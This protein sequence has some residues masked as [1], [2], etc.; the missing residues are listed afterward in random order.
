MA[1]GG[2]GVG[3]RGGAGA[4]VEPPALIGRGHHG[5]PANDGGRRGRWGRRGRPRQC[6]QRRLRPAAQRAIADARPFRPGLVHVHQRAGGHAAHRFRAG[7]GACVHVR[8]GYAH[9]LSQRPVR[10]TAVV[11]AAAGGIG[12]R[13]RAQLRAGVVEGKYIPEGHALPRH[14]LRPALAHAH[15]VPPAAEGDGESVR[16]LFDIDR[17]VAG[18]IDAQAVPAFQR[19]VGVHVHGI[20]PPV[21]RLDGKAQF[22]VQAA[23]AGVLGRMRLDA[24]YGDDLRPARALPQRLRKTR[25]QPRGVAADGG[26]LYRGR[27][28]AKVVGVVLDDAVREVPAPDIARGFGLAAVAGAVIAGGDGGTGVERHIARLVHG[29]DDA[30]GGAVVAAEHLIGGGIH[31][32]IGARGARGHAAQRVV[33]RGHRLRL[34]RLQRPGVGHLVA[35]HAVEIV[36]D[37]DAQYRHDAAAG[38]GEHQ[39]AAVE[40]G[41]GGRSK[42]D[43]PRAA[44][45]ARQR[46]GSAQRRAR[47][48]NGQKQLPAHGVHR[49]LRAG[50]DGA[51]GVA[52]HIIG[53][54]GGKGKARARAQPRQAHADHAVRGRRARPRAKTGAQKQRQRHKSGRRPSPGKARPRMRHKRLPKTARR[55][56]Y[57]PITSR[58]R[59]AFP[60]RGER[61]TF[62]AGFSSQTAGQKKTASQG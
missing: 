61:Y 20:L 37:V 43:A 26:G 47:A 57:P 40:A 55:Q 8:A 30:A 58:A 23:G 42:A 5:L 21:R 38:H 1:H 28:V 10:F 18:G 7:G 49:G 60:A 25:V 48:V 27:G 31:D 51:G 14:G 32:M 19:A 9:H 22:C 3:V 35:H 36:F 4:Q 39:V 50:G 6:E 54:G 17:L 44:L 33:A 34:E 41:I 53:A 62:N 15:A 11:Q 12:K 52:V 24:K 2:H 45:P 56:K 16:A 59:R 13:E 46:A 29:L